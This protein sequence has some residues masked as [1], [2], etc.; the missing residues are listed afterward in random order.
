MMYQPMSDDELPDWLDDLPEKM[1]DNSEF[2]PGYSSEEEQSHEEHTPPEESAEPSSDTEWLDDF[3]EDEV[4]SKDDTPEWLKNIRELKTVTGSLKLPDVKDINDD[5]DWLGNLRPGSDQKE[6]IKEEYIE[7]DIEEDPPEVIEPDPEKPENPDESPEWLEKIRSQQ[8]ISSDQPDL[9]GGD[10]NHPD[11][12]DSIRNKYFEDTQKQKIYEEK[13]EKESSDEE[14]DFQKEDTPDWL[15]GLEEK[16]G[17]GEPQEQ[18][19]KEVKDDLPDWLQDIMA[20][21]AQEEESLVTPSADAESL[22]INDLDEDEGQLSDQLPKE[23]DWIDQ[24]KLDGI[25]I[26]QEDL[27]DW[28]LEPAEPTEDFEIEED[29]IEEL[30]AAEIPSWLDDFVPES[31]LDTSSSP[32]YQPEDV[33]LK[34]PLVELNNPLPLEPAIKNISPPIIPTQDI[35]LTDIQEKH[36]SYIFDLIK[37]EGAGQKIT[38]RGI[39]IPQPILKLVVT[40][41]LFIGIIFPLFGQKNIATPDFMPA[42][43]LSFSEELDALSIDDN[44]LIAVEYQA[45]FAGE[46]ESGTGEILNTILS[47]GAKI[48]FISTNPVGPGLIDHLAKSHISAEFQTDDQEYSSIGYISGGSAAMLRFAEDPIKTSPTFYEDHPTLSAISSIQDY[49]MLLVITDDFNNARSWLEQVQPKL[50]SSTNPANHT[51]FLMITS[52]QLEAL[53]HPYYATDPQKING[54]LTGI[55]GISQFGPSDVQLWD[56]YSRAISISLLIIIFGS[57]SQIISVRFTNRQR[58]QDN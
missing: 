45:A 41:A 53:I 16:S 37:S 58:Q 42:N 32:K 55:K 29:Q 1:E 10:S 19:E 15:H 33:Y 22:D 21:R 18:E 9:E 43:V 2:E 54:Y 6:E 30:E 47:K 8:V 48:D 4:K 23:E 38:S 24:F 27:P 57:V 3:L 56:G 35:L 36:V 34:G 46:L 14:I 17:I 44:V 52:S 5:P 40:L 26:P 28:V 25:E 49:S 11:W 50:I 13:P 51:P 7:E 39:S 31:I 20:G 12:L